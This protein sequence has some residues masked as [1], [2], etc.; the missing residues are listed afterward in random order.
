VLRKT[1]G[2]K[3]KEIGRW[4]KLYSEELLRI[5]FMRLLNKA[6][7]QFWSGNQNIRDHYGDLGIEVKVK[8]SLCL[9]N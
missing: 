3:I 2:I 4:R 8:L 7:S 9:T 1:C 5:F 6:Y